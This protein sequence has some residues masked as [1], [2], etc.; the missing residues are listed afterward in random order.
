VLQQHR[1]VRPNFTL[2]TA[3]KAV[4]SSV[5][6]RVFELEGVTEPWVPE[7]ID[8]LRDDR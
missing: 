1:L 6:A 2:S 7:H 3:P 4:V 5:G 8:Y